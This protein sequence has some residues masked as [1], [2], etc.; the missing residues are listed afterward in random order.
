V[1]AQS[2]KVA[3][4]I[5][6]PSPD[7]RALL[8]CNAALRCYEGG[9]TVAIRLAT[10]EKAQLLDERLWTFSDRCLLC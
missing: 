4:F 7:D 3:E 9:E 8:I 5:K 1:A 2:D 10:S 6:L